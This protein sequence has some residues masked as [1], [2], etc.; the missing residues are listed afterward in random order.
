[1][2][3]PCVCTARAR[4]ALYLTCLS[5]CRFIDV[6]MIAYDYEVLQ[7]KEAFTVEI[8]DT[9]DKLPL[10]LT[11]DQLLNDFIMQ[12][13]VLNPDNRPKTRNICMHPWLDG[14]FDALLAPKPNAPKHK[15]KRRPS[16][17]DV[18]SQSD[19]ALIPCKA[20]GMGGMGSMGAMESSSRDSAVNRLMSNTSYE[21]TAESGTM[22]QDDPGISSLSIDPNYSNKYSPLMTLPA[23]LSNIS[24][25]QSPGFL[26]NQSPSFLGNQSPQILGGKESPPQEED[27][28][29]GRMKSPL[30]ILAGF[31][32]S[33]LKKLSSTSSSGKSNEE[34][35]DKSADMMQMGQ[36]QKKS[37]RGMFGTNS[38]DALNEVT[39]RRRG[40]D[41]EHSVR[42]LPPLDTMGGSNLGTPRN[43]M[44]KIAYSDDKHDDK[45]GVGLGSGSGDVF[46]SAAHGMMAAALSSLGS[47]R[48]MDAPSQPAQSPFKLEPESAANS[49]PSTTSGS[50]VS[51]FGYGNVQYSAPRGSFANDFSCPRG[52]FANDPRG[53]F[54]SDSGSYPQFLGS[55]QR[56]QR[57]MFLNRSSSIPSIGSSVTVS[58]T[59]VT[60]VA[61]PTSSGGTVTPTL[62]N[63]DEESSDEMTSIDE[64]RNFL[65]SGT[66]SF[67]GKK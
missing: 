32:G 16:I 67:A 54:V 7:S 64:L 1:M 20:R 31:F 37:I 55:E 14:A 58:P 40:S 48:R 50:G 17:S 42:Q 8:S 51:F 52:S 44:V 62:R 36:G 57:D 53:S 28:R 59:G 5:C 23:L 9:V 25:T 27:G 65:S 45:S 63:I 21:V 60:P 15:T 22:V 4:C 38:F 10:A 3:Y 26:G 41:G 6:W 39:T 61:T 43:R 29:D 2:I 18:I 30:G 24:G 35:S 46:S 12:L 49:G 11:F 34:L 66:F 47:G 33:N 56:S 13:L 19:S